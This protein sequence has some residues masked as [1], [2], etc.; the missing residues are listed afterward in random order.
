MNG[1]HDLG[2]ME[3][4]GP[5][6][7]ERDEPV[8]HEEWE[9]KVFGTAMATMGPLYNLDEFRHAI[10]RM[11]NLH[12][13]EGSY[14]EHWLASLETLLTE[15]GVL[16]RAELDARVA[17]L[18]EDPAAVPAPHAQGDD[19]LAP[20]IAAAIRSGASTQRPVDHPP[21]FET[22]DRVV[23]RVVSPRGHTRLPRYVRGKAG[24][25]E[26]VH[27][28]F[29]L[30]DTNAHLRGEQPEYVYGVRFDAGEVWGERSR[31]RASIYVDLWERYLE[32]G[33]TS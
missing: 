30:P 31:G 25:V 27:G 32:P 16:D 12:Y 10:E 20:T 5:V 18:K 29:V 7:P 15:K 22:G 33:G 9:G 24:T 13:L 21:R 23:A 19:R 1:I 3:G 4:F 14:Y 28:A 11:G 8:F 6:V 26:I 2:G 17:Q